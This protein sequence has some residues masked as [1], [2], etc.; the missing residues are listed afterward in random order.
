[1]ASLGWGNPL[2]MPDDG[3]AAFPDL[4]QGRS[5]RRR[6]RGR[7]RCNGLPVPAQVL[8]AN[9]PLARPSRQAG[10]L[11][12]NLTKPA[13]LCVRVPGGI[14]SMTRI[15]CVDTVRTAAELKP[16]D[17]EGLEGR[18]LDVPRLQ[19]RSPEGRSNFWCGRASAASSSARS[20]LPAAI[21][22]KLNTT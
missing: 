21:I 11:S 1:M 12:G 4:L 2:A 5:P 7:A 19:Q 6:S 3:D 20:N 15:Q 16:A 8:Q 9:S 10:A 18:W 13:C 22:G 17:L 14:L